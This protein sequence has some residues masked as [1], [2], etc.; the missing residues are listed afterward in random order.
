MHDRARACACVHV[1][2]THAAAAQSSALTHPHHVRVY[3]STPCVHDHTRAPQLSRKHDRFRHAHATV[4]RSLQHVE[5]YRLTDSST[6]TAGRY[7]YL[8][9][10]GL[11]VRHHSRASR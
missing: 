8:N 10:H 9:L 1:R 6:P 5:T 7:L 2:A 11:T 4:L 3:M